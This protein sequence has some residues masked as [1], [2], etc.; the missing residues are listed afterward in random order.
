MRRIR[1]I[2]T[3]VVLS[4]RG[5]S[6]DVL[7]TVLELLGLGLIVACAALV[8]WPAAFGVA[9]VGLLWISHQISRRGTA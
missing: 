9:G 5:P 8:F 3:W 4:S 6:L 1:T 2:T 7:T